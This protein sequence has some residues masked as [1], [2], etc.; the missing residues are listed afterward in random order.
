MRRF[1][2][3]LVILIGFLPPSVA[4]GQD[5]VRAEG[6]ASIVNNRV[7]SARDRAIDSAQRNAVER[8]AGIMVSSST[9]VENFQVKMD[10]IL[11]E[12]KGFITS[13]KI[14]KEERERDLYEVH[15]EAVVETGRLKDRLE[16]VRLIVARKSKPRLMILFS[17]Q[18]QKDA[19]AEAAMARYFMAQGFKLVD[20]EVAR[21]SRDMKA[22]QATAD[23]QQLTGIAQRYGAEVL[24]L[25]RVEVAS[26]SFKMG[27]VEIQSSEVAVSGKVVNGD[28]GEILASDSKNRKGEFKTVTEETALDLA[29]QMKEEI[30]ERWSSEL[31]NTVTVKLVVSGLNYGDLSRFKEILNTE[32]RGL[33]EL[34]QRS[35]ARGQVELDLEV[36]GNTQNVADDLSTIMLNQRKVSILEIT[37]NTIKA[38]LSPK[39]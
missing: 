23:R 12:S 39:K 4:A 36:K 9:E 22:L 38:S 29:K 10:R 15:I 11:S 28:T 3:F 1:L 5:R 16:A 20:A 37:Q 25:G 6:M 14:L 34:Q 31:T 7:D 27:D 35:Y 26:K 18:A 33:K 19:I 21:K 2:L 13:Y 24:I 17:E 8:V 30:L 32:I